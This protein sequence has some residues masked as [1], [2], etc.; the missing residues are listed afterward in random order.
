MQPLATFNPAGQPTG[1]YFEEIHGDGV[2]ADAIAISNEDYQTYIVEQGKWLRDNITGKRIEAIIPVP[3]PEQIIADLTRAL[4]AYYDTTAHERRYDN[5]LTCALRAG[6]AGPFQSEGTAFA[7]WMD[8]CNA[9][10]YQVMLDCQNGIR[11][12]PSA[13]ELIAELPKLIWP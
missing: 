6:F 1:F 13:E 3:P 2:P 5:R 11:G 10:C 7:I 4:E 9:H 8:T 12:I